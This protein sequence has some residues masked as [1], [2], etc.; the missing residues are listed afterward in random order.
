MENP[1]KPVTTSLLYYINEKTKTNYRNAIYLFLSTIYPETK[2]D[3]AS[4]DITGLKYLQEVRN[5]RNPVIDLINAGGTYMEKYAPATISLNLF[6][7]IS[8]LDDNNITLKKRDRQKIFRQLPPSRS[9]RKEAELTSALFQDIYSE[10]PDWTQVMLLMLLASGMR[11]GE[12]LALKTTDINWKEERP[13]INIRMEITKT[14]TAR[15]T[16]LTTEA[17]AALKSY[18]ETRKTNTPLLFP[19]NQTRAEF[20]MRKAADKTGHG[21]PN[22]K[23][24]EVHWHMTRKWFISR[25]SLYASKEVAEELAGHEG[26]LSKSYQRFT[27]E[28]ILEQY[29]L[30]EKYLTLFPGENPSADKNT[31]TYISDEKQIL[32]QYEP[33]EIRHQQ[34]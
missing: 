25:F 3:T 9:I 11:L 10:L 7:A 12:I 8:W 16:Y 24:R 20:Y 19:Q 15:T 33:S 14:K 27:K 29:K 28:Q 2:R 34:I 18:L 13:E 22:G 6:L 31:P 4:L 17:A 23:L 26:Y 32:Y 5:L 1:D 30:A 21:N